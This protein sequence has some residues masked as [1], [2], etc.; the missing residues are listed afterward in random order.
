[1]PE[2]SYKLLPDKIRLKRKI[3]YKGNIKNI[4]SRNQV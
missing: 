4:D 1:M 3:G 2:K